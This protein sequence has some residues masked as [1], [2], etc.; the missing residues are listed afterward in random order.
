MKLGLA[1]AAV[2]LGIATLAYAN[3]DVIKMRQALMGAN[4]QAIKIVVTMARGDMDFDP[5]VAVAALKTIAN[6]AA[7]F[8][9]FFPVGSETGDTKAG[10]AIW[11]DNEGF[12]AASAKLQ[13]DAN[14]G[15][16]AATTLE[17]LQGALGTV[18]SNC[19][20]C[21]ETYRNG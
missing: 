20:A 13:A 1:A 12:R 2:A 16:E 21:H 4:G 6:D 8:P 18:G 10:A 14:A 3:E 17:G 7:E 19:Q 5:V 11:S 15:A 9:D